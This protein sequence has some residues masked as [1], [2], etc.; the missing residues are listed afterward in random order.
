MSKIN[1]IIDKELTTFNR[2]IIA[3]PKDRTALDAFAK[4]NQGSNDI[5]LTQMAVQLGYIS[6]LES[7][8]SELQKDDVECSL[9]LD[10]EMQYQSE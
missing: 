9:A 8:K 2:S 4:A 10:Y 5:I 7:I 3:T 6:A 1:E